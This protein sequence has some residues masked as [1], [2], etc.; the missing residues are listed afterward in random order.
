M[1]DKALRHRKPGP[2]QLQA[3][4]AALHARAARAEETDWGE[5]ELLYGVLEQRAPSPVVSLNRA[6]AVA[7]ARGA[8]EALAL[9]EPLAGPLAGYFY[10]Y[11]VRGW[12][13]Q[14]LGKRPE[15]REA[16]MRAIAL[17]GT[18]AEAAHIR[19]EL[20]SLTKDEKEKA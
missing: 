12:L 17:A 4:I 20:D 2:Y 7:K 10:F 14:K 18:A 3:A 13:M 8:G 16:Y 11:G 9:I 15:A 19:K 5:I 1:V 6:V